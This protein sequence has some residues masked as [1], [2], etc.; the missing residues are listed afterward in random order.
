MFVFKV[1]FDTTQAKEKIMD[2][3]YDMANVPSG[4]SPGSAGGGQSGGGSQGH[5]TGRAR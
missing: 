2:I 3:K 4:G 1:L 5:G